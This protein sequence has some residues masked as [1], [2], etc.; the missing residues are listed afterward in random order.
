MNFCS[1]KKIEQINFLIIL[2]RSLSYL[3]I[4]ILLGLFYPIPSSPKSKYIISKK[5][6]TL[7]KNTLKKDYQLSKI[8]WEKL[9]VNNSPNKKIRW[10]PIDSDHYDY[11]GLNHL[12]L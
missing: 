7:E 2:K 11:L 12:T 9:E 6:Q 5:T 8:S 4:F 10:Q 1:M 3:S